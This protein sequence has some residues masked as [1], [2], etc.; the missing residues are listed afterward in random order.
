M[1]LASYDGEH[2][3]PGA[4][5]ILRNGAD[6]LAELLSTL[7]PRM[8]SQ[9]YLS[10]EQFEQLLAFLQAQSSPSAVDLSHLVPESVPSELPVH[11]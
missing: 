1:G 2:L 3:R 9:P 8:E 10:N 11:D 7:D 5:Q 4:R 6:V